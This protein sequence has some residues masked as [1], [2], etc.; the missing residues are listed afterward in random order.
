MV[1]PDCFL[2]MCRYSV[3]STAVSRGVRDLFDA[4]HDGADFTKFY[5]CSFVNR[6]VSYYQKKLQ[7]WR[8]ASPD[9]V[10]CPS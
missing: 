10:I 5:R 6:E 4:K 8:F 9:E 3:F 1:L 7:S 2:K